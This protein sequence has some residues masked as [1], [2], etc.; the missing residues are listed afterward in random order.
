MEALKPM[1]C[2]INM[3]TNEVKRV[4]NARAEELVLLPEK[5]WVF[6]TKKAWKD[7]EGTTWVKSSTPANPMHPNKVRRIE[8]RLRSSR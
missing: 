4:P 6:T 3:N 2:V 8:N 5:G 1:Q 7:S